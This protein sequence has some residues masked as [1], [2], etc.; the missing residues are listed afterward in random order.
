[1]KKTQL[2]INKSQQNFNIIDIASIWTGITICL[3]S[4]M[5]GGVLIPSFSFKNAVIISIL[6]NLILALLM[7][8]M[9]LPGLKY[10]YS[11]AI[12]NR[13]IFGYPA[14]NYIPSI[15][16]SISLIGWSSILLNLA[17]Q[18]AYEITSH[19][20]MGL[21]A[22]MIMIITAILIIISSFASPQSINVISK[23]NLPLMLFILI[24]ISFI[25]INE[26][27][28]LELINYKPTGRI[29]FYEA[30]NIVVGGTI[31]GAFVSSDICR[32]SKN[33][34]T[35]RNGI[36]LGTLPA[37]L[38]LAI[39]GMFSRLATSY[40]NPIYIIKSLGMGIPVLILIIL[41]TW[42]TIQVSIYS[43]SLSL[44]NLIPNLSRKNAIIIIG[45]ILIT[46]SSLNIINFF[47]SWLIILDNLFAPMIIITLIKYFY[48][49][50]EKIKN[51]DF[52]VITSIGFSL[53]LNNLIT[54]P[55]PSFFTSML[56]TI[57]TYLLLINCSCIQLKELTKQ[58]LS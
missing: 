48:F 58:K 35:I 11:T 54:L 36:L 28:I 7:Y 38:L 30:L 40:W 45:L 31:V 39:I 2:I 8:L 26:Y 27:N 55:F 3:P 44:D 37:A 22:F 5:L 52:K 41:S 57:I 24:W 9:A 43:A 6:A 13:Y 53:I 21:P 50:E 1:M 34:K 4:F 46:I 19:Y 42:T 33:K 47:E 12:L 49:N 10:G 25:I 15:A 17:G 14:G 16:V 18:A 32:Y 51:I 23:F 20:S 29:K 56:W